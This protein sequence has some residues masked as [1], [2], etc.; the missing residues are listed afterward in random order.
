MDFLNSIIICFE[1]L[2]SIYVVKG[3]NGYYNPAKIFTLI[4]VF[5]LVLIGIIF[6]RV[7][8]LSYFGIF[9]IPLAVI[10]FSVGT[11]FAGNLSK[12]EIEKIYS[13]RT[14]YRFYTTR[15]KSLLTIFLVLSFF[16]PVQT[17]LSGGFSLSSL[18]DFNTL[19][20]VNNQLSI[21]R[22][23]DNTHNTS[24][25][26][27]IFL[28]FQ[29]LCPL[30]GGTV[31]NMFQTK[32]WKYISIAALLPCLFSTLT[33]G[34]KMAFITGVM[35]WFVGYICISLCFHIKPKIKFKHI[36]IGVVGISLF[37]TVLILSM[38]FRIG[39]FDMDTF[40]IVLGKFIAYAFGHIS[41][42]DQWLYESS[43]TFLPHTFGAKT[44]FG[45]SN[46]LGIL[47]REQGVFTEMYIVTKDGGM[48]NV[49]T[50]FRLLIDDFGTLGVLLYLVIIGYINQHIYKN[51]LYGFSQIKNIV[52][53]SLTFFTMFWSF[54]TSILAYTSYIVMFVMFFLSLNFI[55]KF[56]HE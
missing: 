35:L 37:F 1:C 53:L 40:A 9:Y 46:Y 16:Q 12:R 48:S 13:K 51:L 15:G 25:L 47:K 11:R 55:M 56:K 24:S 43:D 33:Q 26:G 20:E 14:L 50:I 23:S 34:V 17:I 44:F 7:V 3:I 41:A 45:I 2:A 4:W 5:Q 54:A 8:V 31:Y 52:L 6:N 21:D 10:A 30:F 36:V 18:L 28:V 39:R 29:Y 19:L 32:K 38:M 22:Y 42:F 49:F 27:Q